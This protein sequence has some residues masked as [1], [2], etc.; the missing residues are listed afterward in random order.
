MKHTAKKCILLLAGLALAAVLSGCTFFDSSVEQLF[1]LPRMAEEYTGL[2]QQI[3][4][5]IDQGYEYASPSGGRNI[6][7]VQMVDLEDDGIQEALVFLRRSSDEKPLKIMVFRLEGDTYRCFCTIESS[8]SAVDSVYYQDLNGDGCREIIVGWRISADVQTVAVYVPQ[9]DPYVLLQSG[10]TRFTVTD[11]D[12]DGV[13]SLL[14]FRSDNDGQP[15]AGLY[16][17]KDDVISASYSSVLSYTMAELSR[18]SV[19]VGKLSDGTPAVFA[20]GVNSQGMAMT[21]ILV[22]QESG[23]LTNIAQD[24]TTGLTAA[25]YPYM[26]LK[27]QDIDGDG[28][29]EIPAPETAAAD[30]GSG[31]A[32][33]TAAAVRGLVRWISYCGDESPDVHCVTYHDLSAGWYFRLPD[34]W[35]GEATF[36]T[37][38]N[39]AYESQ[40]VLLSN[41]QPVAALYAL[42]GDNREKRAMMGSRM[43]LKRQNGVT[44]GGELLAGA[45]YC[46]LDEE[47]LRLGFNLVMAEWA[48]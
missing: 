10:Y 19:V 16:I 4:S 21:D 45:N 40:V 1:T 9:P 2:S 35:Q 48:A 39:G 37:A 12:G 43:A 14:L 42:T 15:V 46:G 8:G 29:V 34:T 47:S 18:G 22:W 7:S 30:A 5:L 38:E 41:G 6:Q 23:G 28:S 17:R 36:T 44:Y 26:Q 3:D 31:A 25:V 20:T 27:P 11:L 24:R 13:K 32:A 33:N